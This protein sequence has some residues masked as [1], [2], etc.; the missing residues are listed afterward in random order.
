MSK[1]MEEI[2]VLKDRSDRGRDKIYSSTYCSKVSY[3][4]AMESIYVWL[5]HPLEIFMSILPL[6][7]II[8]LHS[9]QDWRLIPWN[10]QYANVAYAS[11]LCFNLVFGFG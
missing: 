9:S 8:L 4:Q 7:S 11:C 6:I 1:G 2:N 10:P 5:E 3:A